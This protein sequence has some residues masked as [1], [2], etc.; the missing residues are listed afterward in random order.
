MSDELIT[1]EEIKEASRAEQK[2]R[3]EKADLDDCLAKIETAL[4]D[5]NCELFCTPRITPDGRL[6]AEAGVRNRKE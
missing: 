4:K 6:Y 2:A 3:L 5:H 1:K